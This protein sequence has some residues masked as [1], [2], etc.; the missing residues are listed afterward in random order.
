LNHFF[1]HNIEFINNAKLGV[2]DLVHESVNT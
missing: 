2:G 1:H